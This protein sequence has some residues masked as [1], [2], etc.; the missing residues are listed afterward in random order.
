VVTG[1]SV[2]RIGFIFN[3]EKRNR[4]LH[5]G[6]N[7]K[8]E[9]VVLDRSLNATNLNSLPFVPDF[10]LTA[11]GFGIY[12]FNFVNFTSNVEKVFC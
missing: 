10:S 7:L 4:R 2:E 5:L 1:V 6:E 8:Y 9:T 12:I 3:S 11:L